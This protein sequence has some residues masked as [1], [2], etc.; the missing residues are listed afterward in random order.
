MD[1]EDIGLVLIRLVTGGFFF[2]HGAM[3]LF[4]WFG[5]GGFA[6][7][8]TSFERMGFRPLVPFAIA[9][10]ATQLACGLMVVLGV[11]W[12][13]GPVLLLGPMTV[14]VVRVH[15]P[16]IWV[17]EQGIEFPLV[18]GTVMLGIGLLPAGEVSLDNWL[19][20]DLPALATFWVTLA[21]TEAGALL[22]ISTAWRS[23]RG[24]RVA[25]SAEAAPAAPPA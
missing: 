22:A 19:E 7:T 25:G 12:P 4:G 21:L 3:M 17:T 13:V 15:W 16:R 1:S 8:R 23:R 11:L 2:G 20:I 24:M 10:P 5:G 6:R 9:A 18:M 14:A